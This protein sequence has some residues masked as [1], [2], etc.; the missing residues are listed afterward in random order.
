MLYEGDI[1]SLIASWKNRLLNKPMEQAYKDALN[2]CIYD[3]GSLVDRQF[4]EEI[5][6]REAFEKQLEE[7]AKFYEELE[8]ELKENGTVAA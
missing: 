3:L 8:K 1:W 7:D 4:E 6:A 2:D 5:L